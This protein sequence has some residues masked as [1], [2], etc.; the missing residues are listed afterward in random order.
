V[1]NQHQNIARWLLEWFP[2]TMIPARDGANVP[3]VVK[4]LEDIRDGE[5]E[6]S[7]PDDEIDE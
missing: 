1:N 5:L 2:Q 4:W 6:I 3:V 7:E